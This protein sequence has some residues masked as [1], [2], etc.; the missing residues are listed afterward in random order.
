MNWK[1]GQKLVSL[2]GGSL[3]PEHEP[4]EDQIVTFDGCGIYGGIYLYEYNHTSPYHVGRI[5]FW[6]SYFRPLLGESAKSELLA[7]FTEV[8]ET[9]DLPIRV[10][11]T[12]NV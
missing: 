1:I 9:S 4:E 8:T 12:E 5:E 11:Q 3:A 2:Y 6:A 7:S 10:P